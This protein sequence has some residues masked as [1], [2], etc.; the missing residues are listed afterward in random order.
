MRQESSDRGKPVI[1][2]SVGHVD[3]RETGPYGPG[4]WIVQPDMGCAPC[5]FDQVCFH[6][7]CNERLAP[8]QIA[9]LCLHVLT[10]A[11]VPAVMTGVRIYRSRVDEDGLGNAE[12]CAGQE[13]PMTSWYGRFWRRF[14]YEQFTGHSS[15]VPPPSELP[16]DWTEAVA[17]LDHLSPLTASLVSK[18]EE[19]V[20]LTKQ[21]PLPVAALQ[22]MQIREHSDRQ[23]IVALSMQQPATASLAVAMVRDTHSDDGSDLTGMAQSRLATYRRWQRRLQSVIT[24]FR[25]LRKPDPRVNSGVPRP[26]PVARSA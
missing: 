25:S 23:H 26:L 6:H 20:R 7:A 2:L 4:H 19:L 8:D 11:D 15:Q 13:N 1:D 24:Q 10:G 14:W 17:F 18:T 12:L 16:P 5:G 9:G 21:R 22:Q 3:F